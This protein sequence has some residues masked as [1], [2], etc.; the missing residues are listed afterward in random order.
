MCAAATNISDITMKRSNVADEGIS[1]GT[2]G[3]DCDK[4]GLCLQQ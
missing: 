4:V 1:V 3:S 2:E